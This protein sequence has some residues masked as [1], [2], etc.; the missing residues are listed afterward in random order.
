MT[1]RKTVTPV[2]ATAN[3]TIGRLSPISS[4]R[5]TIG[6]T[7]AR[8]AGCRATESSIPAADP[9]ATSNDPSVSASLTSCDRF[10]PSAAR[11]DSS[12]RLAT[13]R[14][15]N[16]VATVAH[17]IKRSN[18]AT[19][20]RRNSDGRVS[21][22]TQSA[23]RSRRV[24]ERCSTGREA[25]SGGRRPRPSGFA[26]ASKVTPGRS[27]PTA[28][29]WVMARPCAG[30]CRISD[31]GCSTHSSVS[32]GY[33]NRNAGGRTPTMVSGRGPRC[34]RPVMNVTDRPTT[35]G[36]P[37]NARCQS[38]WLNTARSLSPA[39]SS[40]AVNTRPVAAPRRGS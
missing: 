15:N 19:P 28:P 14:M 25:S 29:L 34:A 40:S 35:P 27:L 26:P 10:A 38:P 18:D 20:P 11:T 36:S 7:I 12:R 23:A 30:S 13:W 2:T 39:C 21:P 22:L 4:A 24:I 1:E 5:G 6:G 3:T 32:S 8:S 9:S 16:A 17:V 37:P 33:V 31:Q